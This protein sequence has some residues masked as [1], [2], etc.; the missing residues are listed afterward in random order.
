MLSKSDTKCKSMGFLWLISVVLTIGFI[1]SGIHI[2]SDQRC[3]TNTSR[4]ISEETGKPLAYC[5]S[6]LTSLGPSCKTCSAFDRCSSCED[7]FWLSDPIDGKMS[8]TACEDTYG[9]RCNKCDNK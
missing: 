7:T 5:L 8:C 6:C 4:V 3:A 2:F 9:S 1:L